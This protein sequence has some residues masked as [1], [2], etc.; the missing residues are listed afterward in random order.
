MSLGGTSTGPGSAWEGSQERRSRLGKGVPD[1]GQGPA[2][3]FRLELSFVF[4]SLPVL[5]APSLTSAGSKPGLGSAQTHLSCPP[6]GAS[7][8]QGGSGRR[9]EPRLRSGT[10]P[11]RS[12]AR[13]IGKV[14]QSHVLARGSPSPA[15]PCTWRPAASGGTKARGEGGVG[16][17][18]PWAGRAEMSRG[19]GSDGMAAG[20]PPSPC[21]I[22][23]Q[24]GC[25]LKGTAVSRLR[26]CHCRFLLPGGPRRP[27]AR[28]GQAGQASAAR[29]RPG[30][31][32]ARWAPPANKRAP[33][34]L[35]SQRHRVPWAP[36]TEWQE[37]AGRRGQ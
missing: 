16:I 10:R 9:G 5:P 29:A 14:V 13:A 32:A 12:H 17:R 19:K 3:K 2:V 28:G 30:P 11:A 37:R 20:G 22:L 36:G 31:Q 24:M 7:P 35:A 34:G 21:T 33:R 25:P 15:T 8:G 1:S 26:E 6:H 23:I 4:P 18:C 27:P